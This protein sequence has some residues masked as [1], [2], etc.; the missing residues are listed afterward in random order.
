M[1]MGMKG[2]NEGNDKRNTGNNSPTQNVV[3]GK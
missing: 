1:R 2:E 3:P